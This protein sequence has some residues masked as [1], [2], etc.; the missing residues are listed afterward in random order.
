[1]EKPV[2]S[3]NRIIP[4]GFLTA[5][6]RTLTDIPLSDQI[7]RELVSIKESHGEEFGE[8]IV[9]DRLALGVEARY[10]LVNRIL[11]ENQSFQIVELAAG[12]SPRGAL[13]TENPNLKYSELD[14]PEMADLKKEI[15]ARVKPN[16]SDN[17]RIFGGNALSED[18][19]NQAALGF[20]KSKPVTV[21]SEGILGYF[22]FDEK[23]K[24]ARN[25][26]E[27]ISK[28]DGTWISTD[29]PGPS[30]PLWAGR[31]GKLVSDKNFSEDM[32]SDRQHFKQFFEKLG[33]AVSFRN[34]T[35]VLPELVSAERLGISEEEATDRLD[36]YSS[37][38][39]MKSI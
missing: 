11:D 10:K 14:L 22:S 23:R 2:E 6:P 17:L 37:V 18:D 12:L 9:S 4:T 38:A 19:I 29:A 25:I 5:Y 21:I 28:T 36:K 31:S 3:Y 15:L 20:D 13:L 27:I 16:M 26:F 35:E 1:M 8:D 39:I 24:L 33:Y 30:A 32:F 34:L 7:F